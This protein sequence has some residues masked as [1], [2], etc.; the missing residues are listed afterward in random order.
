MIHVRNVHDP[1]FQH[2][3]NNS[4]MKLTA[5]SGFASFTEGKNKFGAN[6]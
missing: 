4:F 6:P 1:M 5:T 3:F 2:H